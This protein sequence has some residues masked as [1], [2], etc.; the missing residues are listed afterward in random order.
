MYRKH[1]NSINFTTKPAV[2][3]CY[4]A[5][6]CTG[7]ALGL[8]GAVIGRGDRCVHKSHAHLTLSFR[9]AESTSVIIPASSFIVM[10]TNERVGVIVGRG[11]FVHAP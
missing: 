9:C 7:E 8:L 2:P 4:C 1:F 6:V 5:R 11:G 10:E 3:L